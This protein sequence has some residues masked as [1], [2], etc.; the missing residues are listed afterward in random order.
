MC[1]KTLPEIEELPE[2]REE[3]NFPDRIF[4]ALFLLLLLFCIPGKL[5]F[6]LT[7][8]RLETLFS[9]SALAA[10]SI[11]FIF[12]ARTGHWK[13]IRELFSRKSFL[14]PFLLLFLLPFLQMGTLSNSLGPENFF[15]PYFYLFLPLFSCI[16]GGS[17]RKKLPV[18]FA[19]TAGIL[20]LITFCGTFSNKYYYHIIYGIPGNRNWNAAL[21]LALSPFLLYFLFTFLRKKFHLSL[22]KSIFILLIPLAMVLYTLYH[23]GSLGTI[24]SIA[25][26]CIF[27]LPAMLP[28]ASLRKKT[29]LILCFLCILLAG[30]L[31]LSREKILPYLYKSGSAAERVEL[32]SS[33]VTVLWKDTP[34]QGNTFAGIEEILSGNRSKNYF[35]VLNPAIRSPHPHNHMLYMMLGWGLVGG[36]IFWGIFL[37]LVPVIKSYFFLIS[38]KGRYEEKLLFLSLVLLLTHA[39]IDLVLEVLPTGAI[40]LLLLGLCWEKSFS[41]GKNCRNETFQLAG[42]GRIFCYI[43]GSSFLFFGVFLAGKQIA[44][45]TLKEKLY[46]TGKP[47]PD[48]EQKKYIQSLAFLA[49]ENPTL[50]YDLMLL[51]L[52][53]HDPRT[54]LFLAGLIEK[55]ATPNYAR[56]HSAKAHAFLML[57]NVDA[58]LE[59]FAKDAQQ[60]PT[61][62]LPIYNMMQIA[63]RN[64]KKQL[65]PLLKKEFEE[66]IHILRLTKE[67]FSSMLKNPV[68][69][70]MP[71]RY[72]DG[73]NYGN[74]KTRFAK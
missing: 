51:S 7:Q 36:L 21:L 54:A 40:T 18:I 41:G 4:P 5:L 60:Y 38:E 10:F 65:L 59:E 8:Y 39:Q 53:Q 72:S 61:A 16:Y 74:W 19:W 56:T 67:E 42:M 48:K 32:F 28:T 73:D 17:F 52:R 35:L 26:G 64:N 29:F 14:Y 47:L 25:G 58:S 12:F 2:K 24:V 34:I 46:S 27:F 43:A 70:L 49:P 50:L 1:E 45:M 9:T 66:R 57:G 37:V 31:F 63:E 55:G 30:L 33:A 11:A 15:L 3:E 68:N 71:W 20:F 22:L 13:R 6:S 69:E 23:T 62:I 44:V